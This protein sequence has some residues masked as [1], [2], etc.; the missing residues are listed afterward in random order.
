MQIFGVCGKDLEH[1]Y[2]VD[3]IN[4][5]A[6]PPTGVV[7]AGFDHSSLELQDQK[8][9]PTRRGPTA[10]FLLHISPRKQSDL[11]LGMC[12]LSERLIV[13]PGNDLSSRQA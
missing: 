3:N 2:Q 10:V 12:N 1:N 9:P 13:V 6:G 7:Q 5:A 11:E 8:I 4:P